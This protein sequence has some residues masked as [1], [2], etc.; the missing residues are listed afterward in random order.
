MVADLDVLNQP[1]DGNNHAG[2]FVAADKRHLGLEWPVSLPRVQIG[3]ADLFVVAQLA[4][5]V[6]K[7]KGRWAF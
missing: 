5:N 1:A 2:A 4:V 7:R 3:M 6:S